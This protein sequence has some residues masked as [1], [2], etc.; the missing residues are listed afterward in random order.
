MKK[1][2]NKWHSILDMPIKDYY[3][4]QADVLEELREGLGDDLD[5]V[6]DAIE[7]AIQEARNELRNE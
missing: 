1:I 3:W 6:A 5:E 2:I 4:H 7:E